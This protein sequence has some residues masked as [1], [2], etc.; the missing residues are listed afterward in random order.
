[1]IIIGHRGIAYPKFKKIVGFDGIAL[2]DNSS[3]VWFE[4]NEDKGYVLSHHCIENNIK[5]ALRVDNITDFVIY[6]SL[7]PLYIILEKSPEV[8]QKIAETYLMD[9][10]IL[11]VIEDEEEI[12]Q[13]AKMGIDGVIFREVL[14]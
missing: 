7:K 5:Y 12:E 11:Y 9:S 10:K 6:A 3:I 2:T 4:A 13:L 8:Y 14:E 1:M